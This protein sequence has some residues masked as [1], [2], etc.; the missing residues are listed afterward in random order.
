MVKLV[1]AAIIRRLNYLIAW[2][3]AAE[4]ARAIANKFF[5]ISRFF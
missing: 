3:T 4:H 5:N 1:A 2:P